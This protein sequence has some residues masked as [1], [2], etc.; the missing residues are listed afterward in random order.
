[1]IKQV[2]IQKISEH[3]TTGV[4]L[5]IPR[6]YHEYKQQLIFTTEKVVEYLK[7][8]PK[9][10]AD[11]DDVKNLL[12]PKVDVLKNLVKTADFQKVVL[13]D[14]VRLASEE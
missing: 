13:S 6:Y 5:Q 14:Q 4:L 1:V 12:N 10:M 2:Y 11:Y 9:F 8:K 7:T 3:H